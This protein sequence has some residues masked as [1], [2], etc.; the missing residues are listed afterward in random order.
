MRFDEIGADSFNYNVVQREYS[1]E[2]LKNDVIDYTDNKSV[3]KLTL[4]YYG[5]N[6]DIRFYEKFEQLKKVTFKGVNRQY[7]CQLLSV[8]E[9]GFYSEVWTI[10]L[11]YRCSIFGNSYKVEIPSN[12]LPNFEIYINSKVPTPIKLTVE[13]QGRITINHLNFNMKDKTAVIDSLNGT[14]SGVS[15]WNFYKF[16]YLD[17]KTQITTTGN[18]KKIIME[19]R[20]AYVT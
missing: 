1:A 11:L 10:T 6:G 20:T 15:E 12:L 5:K 8:E 2:I 7:D 18:I 14:V 17:N 9:F 13:G 19:Y 4:F 3:L 16:L